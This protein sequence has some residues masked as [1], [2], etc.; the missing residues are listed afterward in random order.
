ML[1]EM[2]RT[3][4]L[5]DCSTY[6][7]VDGMEEMILVVF[8]GSRLL[9]DSLVSSMLQVNPQLNVRP[10]AVFQWLQALKY[11]HS[12]YRDITIDDSDDMRAT[13]N[14]IGDKIIGAATVIEEDVEVIMD[15]ISTEEAQ[16]TNLNQSNSN[17]NSCMADASGNEN[18]NSDFV[19]PNVFPSVFLTRSGEQHRHANAA[20]NSVLQSESEHIFP[21]NL[22]NNLRGFLF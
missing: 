5:R 12:A 6:P 3:R 20:Q 8:I 21:S 2:K 16:E 13:L 19:E 18:Q 7:R 1:A 17:V 22:K 14:E 15:K 10:D 11:L 4:I 9:W